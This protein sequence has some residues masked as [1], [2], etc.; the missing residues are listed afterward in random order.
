MTVFECIF[1]IVTLNTV[2]QLAL[3]EPFSLGSETLLSLLC[4]VT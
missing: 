4:H 2:F 1:R 3:S